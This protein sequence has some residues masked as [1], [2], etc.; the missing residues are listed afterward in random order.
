MSK[1]TKPKEISPFIWFFDHDDMLTVL[2]YLVHNNGNKVELEN[3]ERHLGFS[4]FYLKKNILKHLTTTKIIKKTTDGYEFTSSPAAKAFLKL[5]EE[6]E[7]VRK[8]LP[9][10]QEEQIQP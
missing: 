5:N 4:D 3:M 8:E 10:P 7:R 6:L 9:I 1:P 2:N